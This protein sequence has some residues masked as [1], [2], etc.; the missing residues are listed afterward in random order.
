MRQPRGKD[1]KLEVLYQLV[2]LARIPKQLRFYEDSAKVVQRRLAPNF[3]KSFEKALRSAK[4]QSNSSCS[5]SSWGAQILRRY[6]VTK[7]PYFGQIPAEFACKITPT[8]SV[9]VDD[10]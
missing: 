8:N 4:R 6:I 9:E 3:R 7:L 2:P 1:K 5:T 10:V